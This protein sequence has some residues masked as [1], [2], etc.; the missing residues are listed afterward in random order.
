MNTLGR[1]NRAGAQQAPIKHEQAPL[2]APTCT[3][4]VKNEGFCERESDVI[5]TR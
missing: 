2:G 1:R 5:D 3:S 4:D